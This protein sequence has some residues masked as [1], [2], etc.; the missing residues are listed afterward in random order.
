M[1]NLLMYMFKCLYNLVSIRYRICQRLTFSFIN[2]FTLHSESSI[3]NN[4]YVIIIMCFIFFI[5][6]FLMANFLN[7]LCMLELRG[8]HSVCTQPNRQP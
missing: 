4:E 7:Y 1:S 3:I 5:H 8:Y 6:K 2:Q